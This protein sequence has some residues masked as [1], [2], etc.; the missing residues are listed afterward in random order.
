MNGR[1]HA[2]ALRV[3]GGCALL[4]AAWQIATPALGVPDYLLPTPGVV[5][6]KFWETLPVQIEH[7]TVT[8]ATTLAGLG[9]ALA[10]GMLLGRLELFTVLILFFPQ[11]W[12]D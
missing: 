6:R 12:R 3:A 5:A 1:S 11:F 8:A 9:L 4:I 10:F 2:G 7:L